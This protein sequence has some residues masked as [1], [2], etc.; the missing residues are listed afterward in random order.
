M[1]N[2]SVPE[3]VEGPNGRMTLRQAQGPM[4]KNFQRILLPTDLQ[5]VGKRL[6]A[7]CKSAGA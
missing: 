6:P 5:S 3:P 4:V 7:D 2:A 1:K